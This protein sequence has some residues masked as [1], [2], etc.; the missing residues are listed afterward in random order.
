MAKHHFGQCLRG[1]KLGHSYVLGNNPQDDID[2]FKKKSHNFHI[3]P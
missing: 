3:S 1:S 2:R